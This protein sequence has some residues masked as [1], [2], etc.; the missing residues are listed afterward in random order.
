[1]ACSTHGSDENAYE[2]ILENL[3]RK[4]PLDRPSHRWEDNIKIG[5]KEIGC[6]NIASDPR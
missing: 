5:F 2:I 6:E 1:M 3:E 4:K